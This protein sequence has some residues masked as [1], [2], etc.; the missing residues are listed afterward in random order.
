M[1]HHPSYLLVVCGP[2]ASGKTS[3]GIQL[4]KAFDTFIISAD[5]RQFYKEMTIGTAKPSL[6]E[7]AAI[8]HYFIDNVSIFDKYTVGDYER[9]VIALLNQQ[10]QTHKVIVMVG[11]SGLFIDAVCHGIDTFPEVP[12]ALRAELNLLF[13]QE[14]LLPLQEKLQQLDPNYYAIVDK[15]NHR[16]LIRALEI[17]IAS[18]QPYS[19]FIKQTNTKR[20][21]EVIKIAIEWDRAALNDRIAKRVLDMEVQG[22]LDEVTALYPHK[23]LSVLNTI[24]YSEIFD[25]LDHKVSYDDAIKQLITNSKRY[26]KRQM[27]W[28][29]KDKDIAW[30]AIDDVDKISNVLQKRIDKNE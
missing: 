3:L 2:T 30:F 28:F 9:E 24:G 19:S 11:G 27:T 29:R 8:K 6:E 1:N 15:N 23:D 7:Q 26:A 22:L 14:G 5:S 21:F 10:F 4:A 25:F 17:C 18:E 13:E 12:T 16:R 20:D